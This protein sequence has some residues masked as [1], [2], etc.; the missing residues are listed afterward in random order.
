MSAPAAETRPPADPSADKLAALRARYRSQRQALLDDM[1]ACALP[2]APASRLPRAMAAL[3]RLA[4]ETLAALWQR[5]G[6]PGALAAVGG[7]GRS[8]LFP[9]SDVDVL[10]LLPDEAGPPASLDAAVSA[11]VAACWDVGLEVSHSVRTV[12]QCL[13]AARQ[14][15]TACTAWLEARRVAGDAALLARFEAAFAAQLDPLAFLAAKQLE[16]RQRHARQQDTP[17]ALEPDC[18]ESPG[19]LRDLHTI[20]WVARAAG[21]GRSWAD[22]ARSVATAR[23]ARQLARNER[24]LWLIR[25]RLHLLAGRHE[26]RLVFERQAAVA[27]AF[28]YENRFDARGRL[29]QRASEQLMRRYYWCAKAVVQLSEI[30]LQVMAQRLRAAREAPPPSR[31][32]NAWFSETDGALDI[33]RD[34]LY[35]RHPRA[36]LQ[37][38]WLYQSRPE[39]QSL[40]ARTLRALYNARAAMD[41]RFRADPAN[42]ALFMR[43]LKAPAGQTHALRLMNRTSVLGRY[44]WVFRR[45]VG[46]MQHDLF[47]VYTVD[48]HT[49]MVLGNMRR[50][51]MPEFAHEYPLCSQLAQGWQRPWV[52]YVAALFHDIAKGRGG[53]H[54]EL[55]A[56]EVRRFC[57]QMGIHGDDAALAEFLVREHL[58]MSQVA[59]K[60]DVSDPAVIAGFAARVQT[61]RRLAGLYLLTVADIRGTSPKVW[62]GWKDRLLQDLYHATARHL[63]GHAASASALAAS[64]QRQALALLPAGGHAAARS[65]W[66]TLDGSYFTRHSASEIAWHAQSL[67]HE[68][69]GAAEGRPVIA[70]RGAPGGEGL[71]VLVHAPDQPDLFAR[72]CGWFHRAGLSIHDARIHTSRSG[73]ALDTF[74][75]SSAH[76]LA[77]EADAGEA[78]E[79]KAA[80]AALIAR[81]QTGLAAALASRAA[82]PAVRLG[83][84]SARVRS[85]PL[86]PHV[87]W[88]SDDSGQRWRLSVTASDRAGLLY[89]ISR[90]LAAHGISVELARIS[91]LGERAEDTFLLHSPDLAHASV[92]MQVEQELIAALQGSPPAKA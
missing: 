35:Q 24:L 68:G 36:I 25:A 63:G 29:A 33:H 2:A 84:Q 91:T 19:G 4:D 43:M 32:I 27:A 26:D 11:F 74:Q 31:R 12:A 65:L 30:L 20:R 7:Y 89:G 1:R 81:V 42:H 69:S 61:Q 21:F 13:Q 59:Q 15:I 67:L 56:R 47:H 52:L 57:R 80:T 82:L 88:Q 79:Q 71:Q 38:F 86:T 66:A 46:Q 62:N 76:P 23:E 78:D 75:I 87:E 9:F 16:Q 60:Q 37:T 28:G 85:F 5:A 64:R 55:G 58:G 6:L 8:E 10:I 53:D 34:D 45:I 50:F 18:K 39:V 54:S 3:A 77:G 14:D 92:Q 83:R 40:G 49:L 72:L 41:G 70:A 17:Y 90:V 22:L 51:F 48:Q 44:L 73:W